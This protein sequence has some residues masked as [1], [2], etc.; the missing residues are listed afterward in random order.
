MTDLTQPMQCLVTIAFGGGAYY[1]LADPR[2]SPQ[3]RAFASHIIALII[4]FWL[5]G[6]G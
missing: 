3:T 2:T 4:G 1:I 6:H 5:R